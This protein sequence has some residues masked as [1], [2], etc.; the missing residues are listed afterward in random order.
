MKNKKTPISEDEIELML[1]E[2]MI[3]TQKENAKNRMEK[4][5][6]K[7]HVYVCN[8]WGSVMVFVAPSHRSVVDHILERGYMGTI[9]PMDLSD[10]I[11][12]LP[13]GGYK[14]GKVTLVCAGD[15]DIAR[16]YDRRKEAEKN[17]GANI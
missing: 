6:E 16:E 5:R 17:A 4:V 7:L 3:Q 14:E 8:V 9:G 15:T 2:S 11:W 13:L 1:I 12:E 10:S